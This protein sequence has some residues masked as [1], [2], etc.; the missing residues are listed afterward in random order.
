MGYTTEFDGHFTF[1]K[2]L[3]D[4]ALK[5]FYDITDDAYPGPDS[6]CDWQ[7]GDDNATLGWNG[8]EKFYHWQEWLQYIV[9]QILTPAGVMMN[10]TVDYQGEDRDDF[11][12]IVVIDNVVKKMVGKVVTVSTR[13]YEEEK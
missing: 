6:P 11:G 12:Q 7:L 8:M 10:G 1:D 13:T 3:D 5:A 4:T 2:P 9:D